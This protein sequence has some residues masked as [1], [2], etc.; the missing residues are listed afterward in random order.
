MHLAFKELMTN[1]SSS[2]QLSLIHIQ[3]FQMRR[4]MT[5]SMPMGT[6][7]RMDI[8]F[9]ARVMGRCPKV[10]AMSNRRVYSDQSTSH[11]DLLGTHLLI[12][13]T[14]PKCLN[15]VKLKGYKIIQKIYVIVSFLVPIIFLPWPF[16]SVQYGKQGYVCWLRDPASSCD[17]SS[18][19]N[20][21]T[22]LLMWLYLC[23]CT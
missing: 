18:L 1:Q 8:Q 11:C 23:G 13:M 20:M 12:L 10:L 16:I 4:L 22:L 7:L 9:L 3:I 14:M 2:L 6:V 19:S 15:K 17:N 5:N 21:V